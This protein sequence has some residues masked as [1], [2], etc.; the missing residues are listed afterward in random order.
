MNG[1]TAFK[2]F[3]IGQWKRDTILMLHE[4]NVLL[5]ESIITAIIPLQIVVGS[6]ALFKQV[7]AGYQYGR[8]QVHFDV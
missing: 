2:A 3:I 6:I 8:K 4:E 5:T 1:E 7:I